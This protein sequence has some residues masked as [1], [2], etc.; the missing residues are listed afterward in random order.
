[1]LLAFVLAASTGAFAQGA[2]T[3][4]LTGTVA[5][6]SGAVVPGADVNAKN[7]ATATVYT[8]VSGSNGTF[9]ISA[10]EPGTYTVTVALMGFKTAILNDVVVYAGVPASV[11]AILELGKLEETVVVEAATQLVQTQSAAVASTINVKQITSLPLPGR[12]AFDF[13]NQLPGVALTG[14]SSRGATVNGLPQSAVNITLD[15]MNIQDNYAKSW[16]GMFTRV[17]PRLDAVE[18]L[19]VGSAANNSSDS[20]QGGI[21][22]RFVTRSGTNQFRGSAYYYLQDD[23]YNTNTWF[24]LHRNV[25]INGVPTVKPAQHNDQPGFRIGGPIVKDKAFFFVNYEWISSPTTLTLTP[26]VMSPSSEQGIFQYSGGSKDLMALAAS[27]GYTSKIDPL[28]AKTI[29]SMRSSMSGKTLNATTDPLTQQMTWQLPTTGTTKYP[30]VRIDW[31]ATSKHRVTFSTT[32]NHLI[33]DPDTTN[34]YYVSYPGF[35]NRGTQDSVRYSGQ[36]TLRSTLGANLVNEVRVGATGGATQFFPSNNPSMFTD[37]GGYALG[38]SAFKSI[39]NPYSTSTNSSREGAT[40]VVEDNVTWQKGR[41]AI[42]FGGS[43]TQGRV[44]LKNQQMVPTIGFGIATGDPADAMFTTANFPG[45]S[46]TDLTNARN[47][48]AVLTGR[49]NSIGR[50]ARIGTDGTTYNILGESLQEGR[51]PEYN[52]YVQ[53]SW[54]MKPSLTVNAGLRYALQMPFYAVNNSYS[55]A[56]INSIMGVT[57]QGTGFTVGSTVTDL[58]NMFQPGVLQGAAPTLTMLTSNTNAYNIDTNNLAPSVGVAWTVGS[59]KGFAHKLLGSPGDSVLRGGFSVAYQRPGMNDFTQVFGTNPG[60]SIDATRNQTNG[61]LG[62]PP[63]LLSSGDLSAPAISLTRTY[64]MSIPSAGTSIYAFDPNI[65]VTRTQ[66][67]TFGMQRALGKTMM[68]EARYIHTNTYGEWTGITTGYLNYNELNV[69]TNGFAKEFRVAQA[70]LQANIAAGKGNT[71]AYTGA[72]GTS[73][74]PIF[75][76]YLNGVNSASSGDTTKYSGTGW[77]NTTLVSY[78][79]PLNPN[80]LSAASNLRTTASY[81]ANAVTAGLPVNFMVANPNVS[82]ANVMANGAGRYYNGIQ[83]VFTRRFAHGLQ[84]NANYTYGRGDQ[85]VFYSFQRPYQWIEQNYT[86]SGSGNATGNV[87]HI[88]VANAVYELPFGQGKPIG[89]NVGQ[90]WQ[91]LIGNWTVSTVVRL[92]SGRMVDFGNVNMVGFT[93]KDLQGFYGTRKVTDPANPYRTL[94]YMLPQDVIDNTILAY[95]FNATGYSGAAPTGRYFMPASGPSCLE[96]ASN[97]YGDCG[98]RSIIVQGPMVFRVD[99]NVIKEVQIVKRA[100]FRF[101]LMVFNLF[102]NVNFNPVSYVGSVSDS[103]QST[104]AIDQSRT[105]QLA[106]RVT[107]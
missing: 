68:V 4:T 76:A 31:N 56:D 78:L 99:F 46:T 106:F 60:V 79:Y 24:N 53:D 87:R 26:T 101:E 10:V 103:Y 102:N 59:D 104:S 8:A 55:N 58:G 91:R 84:A 57:G 39:A 2:A 50:N 82:G 86:N 48:Y 19:S 94:V 61:N 44:W 13:V 33:S 7:K 98:Q 41:H 35:P 66:S 22:V 14:G 37:Y 89:G 107:W 69:N 71:F 12:G 67:G 29:A 1:M 77:T 49:V 34:G 96:T 64:P 9:T 6:A 95:S 42:S 25:D 92:Q 85:S 16:D 80:V 5:D 62:T 18:E 72:A 81:V 21:Q 11:K 73:P 70:N 23:K 40:R 20:G 27:L 83:L 74:L 15:G 51:M 88:F 36:A 32:Y 100:V 52:F 28:I 105:M 3:S 30:T 47:L 43:F 17:S 54:R 90:W 65:Q 93:Q 38:M 45:A 75:L 97:S 63:I